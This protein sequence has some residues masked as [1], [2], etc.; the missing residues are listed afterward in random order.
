LFGCVSFAGDPIGCARFLGLVSFDCHPGQPFFLHRRRTLLL[1]V[2][3]FSFRH[4]LFL[5]PQKATPVPTTTLTLS[6][7]KSPPGCPVRCHGQSCSRAAGRARDGERGQRMSTVA[8]SKADASMSP[9]PWARC[10]PPHCRHGCDTAFDPP[11]RPRSPC[12]KSS[13]R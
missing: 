10:R 2:S 8:S 13:S 9:P 3:V 7:Q 1:L 6:P 4:H 12:R 11:P 5:S